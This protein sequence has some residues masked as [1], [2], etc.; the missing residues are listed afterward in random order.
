MGL[1]LNFGLFVQYS[2][3]N[4]DIRDVI[5]VVIFNHLKE[6]YKILSSERIAQILLK[7]H[8]L[9]AKFVETSELLENFINAGGC[10]STERF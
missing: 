8:E 2:I 1:A 9:A 6:N 4:F 5:C 10:G 3:I 7:R